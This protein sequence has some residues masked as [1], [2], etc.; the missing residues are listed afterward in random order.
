LRPGGPSRTIRPVAGDGTPSGFDAREAPRQ[1]R[2]AA[3]ERLADAVAEGLG[4][5][6]RLV[7]HDNRSVMVSYRRVRGEVRLRVHHLFLG[8]PPDVAR[9]LG[10]FTASGRP[11][12]RRE[13]SRRIEAW[14]KEQRDRIAAPPARELHARGRFHDLQEM[15]DRLNAEHFGGAVRAR[16]GWGR[17]GI[18]PGRRSIKT[19]VYLHHARAIRIHP[20]L[21]REDVPA[22]YVEAVVFHEMLHEVVPLGERGGRRVVHGPEFRRRERRFPG[23]ARARAWERA[24]LHLLLAGPRRR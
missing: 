23:Y 15:L 11:A 10:A 18:R 5:R 12:A 24:H 16:I 1:E 6:V 7:V 3:A 17:S 14:V 21:D 4:E 9:A 22:Y 2:L 8:A 20:A 19:G 13:A